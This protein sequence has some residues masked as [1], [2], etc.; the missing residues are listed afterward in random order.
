MIIKIEKTQ[1]DIDCNWIKTRNGF[2][3]VCTLKN[4]DNFYTLET[5]KANYINRTWEAWQYR[6]C[7]YGLIAKFLKNRNIKTVSIEK[8]MLSIDKKMQGK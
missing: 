1:Y 7:I 3:H 4:K 6:S 5:Y 8:I 2:A